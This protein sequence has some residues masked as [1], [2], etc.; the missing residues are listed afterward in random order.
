M[1]N[2]PTGESVETTG[3]QMSPTGE[4]QQLTTAEQT[5]QETNSREQSQESVS[6]D[7][8]NQPQNQEAQTTQTQTQQNG[9]DS[10]TDDGLAKFAKSQGINDTTQL[11]DT[12]QRLLKIAY[13]NQKAFRNSRND[14]KTL[15]DTVG[16]LGDGSLQAK[17]EQL[18]YE[19]KMDKFF[20]PDS[21]RDRSLEDSM[22][23]IV[24]EKAKQFGN[25]YAYALSQ[26]LPTL[27]G[28][29]AMNTQGNQ[30]QVDVEAIR[31]EE[32]ESIRR[33]S[34]ASDP[35]A[36]A[37]TGHSSQGQTQVTE[38]W[39]ENEYNPRD[40]AHRKLVEAAFGAQ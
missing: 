24:Q 11:D 31:R 8:A 40:P 1:T 23:Q 16:E 36:H 39:L 9:G 25:D 10:T 2:S 33:Q 19:R 13:D 34:A 21:G 17:V 38:E 35:S 22:V 18:E 28:L 5:N 4:E 14:G 30:P 27:Y 3:A 20:S 32:R 6:D 7:T 15:E 37:S 12:A 26:D 29:A